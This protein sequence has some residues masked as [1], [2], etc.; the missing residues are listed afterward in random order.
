MDVT[1]IEP[2]PPARKE[3]WGKTLKVL[4]DIAYAE[5]RRDFRSLKCPEVVPKFVGLFLGLRQCLQT[6]DS[7]L[8]QRRILFEGLRNPSHR[9][10]MF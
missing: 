1:G 5:N 7:Q 8:R 9:F 3:S 6:S 4:S 10:E 2:V